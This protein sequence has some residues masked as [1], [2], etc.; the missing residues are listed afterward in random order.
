VLASFVGVMADP[1]RAGFWTQSLMWGLL[2][3]LVLAPIY[4]FTSASLFSESTEQTSQPSMPEETASTPQTETEAEAFDAGE[5]REAPPTRVLQA[6]GSRKL[7]P[8]EE[9]EAVEA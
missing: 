4:A 6:P 7:W 1:A 8:T 9:E 3:G 2:S 5:S